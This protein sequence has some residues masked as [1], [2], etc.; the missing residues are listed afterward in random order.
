MLLSLKAPVMLSPVGWPWAEWGSGGL[1]GRAS[2]LGT[3]QA[4]VSN[5]GEAEGQGGRGL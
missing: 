1:Q 3:W 5:Q 2:S 4:S